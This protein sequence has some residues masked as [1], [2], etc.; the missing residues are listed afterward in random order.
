V[1]ERATGPENPVKAEHVSALD[2][3]RAVAVLLVILFHLRVPGFRAGFVGVDIFFVLSGFLI[4]SLL[5]EEIRRTGRVSL[6]AFWAR[7]ARRLLPALVL[8]LLTVGVVTALTATYTERASMRGDLL[9]TTGYVA[10]WHFIQT[11][12]YFADIGVDSPLEHTWSLAIEEQFYVLWPLLVFGVARVGMRPRTGVG[13]L[14]LLGVAVSAG[15][16]AVLWSPGDVERAYMGTDARIFEP[17][18]G[19]AGAAFVASPGGRAR[20]ERSGTWVLAAGVA[21]LAIALVFI[22]PG[23][24]E[25]FFGGAVLVSLGTLA[26]LGPLWVRAGGIARPVLAWKPLVWIGVV[27]YGAY[28]WHWPVTLWLRVREPGVDDLIPRRL[29]AFALTFCLAA[30]SFYALEKP[31]RSG[32]FLASWRPHKDV[33]RRRADLIRRR[34]VATLLAVPITLVGVAGVSLALTRVPPIGEGVPVVM[35]VGDSVPARLGTALEG[36]FT[37]EGWRFVSAALGGCPPTGEIPVRPDGTP[38]PGV[39]PGCR[40]EVARRQDSLIAAVDPDVIVWWDRFSV[41]GFLDEDGAHVPAGSAR[42]WSLRSEALDAAVDRLRGRGAIVVFIGAEPPAESVL[43]RC[44]EVGCDW[45]RFQIARYEDVT[46]LWNAMLREYAGTHPDVTG[47]VSI[48]D[49]ICREDVA[50]C[51]DR[52]GG[53]TARRDGVH[54]EGAG[55]EAVIDALLEMLGPFME[56]FEPP[57][58]A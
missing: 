49:A 23:G 33:A 37:E 16:L 55:E 4:T 1:T 40:S 17:L 9:A 44:A 31:I 43:D 52:I 3:M 32:S 47:F 5:L 50:P 20:L 25:Y 45:P 6:S 26:I 39:L 58:A 30:V 19:A 10:N 21:A 11:S 48:T 53:I 36:A 28:L 2:G 24:R 38:W 18:L 15:L 42:F 51:D 46:V 34:T 56:R 14:A 8:L 41:S 13:T 57:S 22:T 35:F 7:R 54:Y 12:T 27:S 29:A